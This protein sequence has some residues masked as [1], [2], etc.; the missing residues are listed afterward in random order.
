[1]TK[2]GDERVELAAKADAEGGVEQGGEQRE[3]G[4]DYAEQRDRGGEADDPNDRENQPD[5]LGEFQRRHWFAFT[6]RGDARSP[7]KP[8]NVFGTDNFIGG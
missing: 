8:A 1:V 4:G 7:A 6:G 5:Q 2:S 3:R